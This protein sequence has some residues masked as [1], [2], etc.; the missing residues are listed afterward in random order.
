MADAQL[1]EIV[2]ETIKLM[3]SVIKKPPMTEKLLSK[4]PFRFLHDTIMEVKWLGLLCV[5]AECNELVAERA[6][7]LSL[8]L[9]HSNHPILGRTLLCK[10]IRN[11]V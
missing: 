3:G 10:R 6:V 1:L 5:C 7:S 9:G 11:H 4:P 2:N 8:K